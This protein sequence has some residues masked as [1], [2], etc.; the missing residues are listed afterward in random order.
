MPPIPILPTIQKFLHQSP[1]ASLE[2]TFAH[3][4]VFSSRP[5]LHFAPVQR[6]NSRVV[7]NK[8]PK[9]GLAQMVVIDHMVFNFSFGFVPPS[10]EPF[11]LGSML[12]LPRPLDQGHLHMDADQLT[13]QF[14]ID[15]P[16][17]ELQVHLSQTYAHILKLEHF[18]TPYLI[19]EH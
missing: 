8:R 2:I 1:Y 5:Q 19:P 12:Q 14:R 6:H 7:I 18:A 3:H 16:R 9:N 4:T 15:A 10:R 11:Y 17:P 13:L